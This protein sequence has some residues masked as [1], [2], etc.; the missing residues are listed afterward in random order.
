M[1]IVIKQLLLSLILSI[2]LTLVYFFNLKNNIQN[3]K[4]NFYIK[5]FIINFI[6]INIA[7]YCGYTLFNE[8]NKNDLN[9]NDFEIDSGNPDF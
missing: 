6:F 8:N 4:K 7:F 2:I 1:K 9:I 3:V 5:I